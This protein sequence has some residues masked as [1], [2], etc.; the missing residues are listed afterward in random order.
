MS[1]RPGLTEQERDEGPYAGRRI[2]LRSGAI[3]ARNLPPAPATLTRPFGTSEGIG[4]TAP[5]GEED[6]SAAA[7]SGY[8]SGGTLL[9]AGVV[10]WDMVF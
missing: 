9:V 8:G 2:I 1:T 3:A 4:G 5:S 10:G 6:V 7:E